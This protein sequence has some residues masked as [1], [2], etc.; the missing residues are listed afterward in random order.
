MGTEDIPKN[1]LIAK[2]LSDQEKQNFIN[3]L[4]ETKINFAWSCADMLGLDLDLVVHNLIVCLDTKLIK[5]K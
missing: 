1:V 5:K 4:T 3:F 2:S